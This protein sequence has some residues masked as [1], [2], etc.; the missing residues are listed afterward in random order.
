MLVNYYTGDSIGLESRERLTQ[1]CP[2][3]P[4]LLDH[5]YTAVSILTSSVGSLSYLFHPHKIWGA[6]LV[7]KVFGVQA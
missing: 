7:G 1:P 2:Y 5:H 4:V 3:L 6:G